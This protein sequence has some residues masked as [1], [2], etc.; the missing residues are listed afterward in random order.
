MIKTKKAKRKKNI[1]IIDDDKSIRTIL[2]FILNQN[3]FNTLCLN[4]NIIDEILT[5]KNIDLI[6]LDNHIEKTTTEKLFKL[7]SKYHPKT[8]IISMVG[9]KINKAYLSNSMH[10]II[11][12]IY[13]PLDT[14]EVIKKLQYILK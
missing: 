11:S 13:K 1:V 4:D 6:L 7:I 3:H 10:N 14:E 2:E 9:K 5:E 12:Y 8:P